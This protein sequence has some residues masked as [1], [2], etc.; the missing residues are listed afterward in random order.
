MLAPLII[1]S[2]GINQLKV[3]QMLYK[4][5]FCDRMEFSLLILFGLY[6]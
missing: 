6:M 5:Y 4:Y 1:Y 2:A 3:S